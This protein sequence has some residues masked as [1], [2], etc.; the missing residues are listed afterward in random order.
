MLYLQVGFSEILGFQDLMH[1]QDYLER[2]EDAVDVIVIT[3]DDENAESS[4][5]QKRHVDNHIKD[6]LP[7]IDTVPNDTVL[8]PNENNTAGN[9]RAKFETKSATNASVFNHPAQVL[10]LRQ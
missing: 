6:F 10:A 5:L 9:S 8:H 1:F 3:E 7:A 4:W 2:K